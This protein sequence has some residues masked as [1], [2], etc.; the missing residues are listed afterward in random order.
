MKKFLVWIV[1]FVAMTLQT[2]CGGQIKIQV[3]VSDQVAKEILRGK[4]AVVFG[5][6]KFVTNSRTKLE[7]YGMTITTATD[8]KEAISLSGNGFV[9][10]H[11]VDEGNKESVILAEKPS[12]ALWDGK[13]AIVKC[14]MGI[15]FLNFRTTEPDIFAPNSSQEI[16]RE[17]HS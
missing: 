10:I 6:Q 17:A 16:E 4:Q 1:I 15:I 7:S 14:P 8:L 2:G 12:N 11:C 3:A 13:N 9:E 5:D